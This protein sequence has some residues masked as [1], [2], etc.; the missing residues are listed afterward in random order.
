MSE[1]FDSDLTSV[2]SETVR[3]ASKKSRPLHIQGSGS[4]SFY[5]RRISG[6]ELD[7]SGHR[8]ILSYEPSELVLT[9]RGG[10]TLA[11]IES[12]LNA[13][14]QMLPFE[15]PRFG[16][17]ATIGGT[18]A[19]GF[20][21]PRRPFAGSARDFVLG[22]KMLDGA[23]KIASFGG[24]VMK[25][26]AGYDVSRLMTGALGTLGVILEVSL[27]V[28]PLPEVEQEYQRKMGASDALAEM[29]RLCSMPLPLS[30]ASHDG[31]TMRVRLSGTS[32][33]V[34]AASE[35]LKEGFEPSESAYFNRLREHDLNFFDE[36]ER[37]WRISLPADAPE[38]GVSG[39]WLADWA[40]ALRWGFSPLSV[41]EVRSEAVRLGGHASIFRSESRDDE[42]FTRLTP[43]IANLHARLKDKFDP[44]RILNPGILYAEL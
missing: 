22:V 4:K 40:G 30:A 5:G 12:I 7:V 17:D 29:Q 36:K 6:T 42:R 9:A 25:N 43:Q 18:V 41:D 2:L 38:L 33:G 1:K 20:S 16:P 23:G 21:G 31:E 32:S 8:G 15:P 13:S 44:Q 26:V 10:T 39:R 28:L 14:G 24:Q 34:E 11:E 3:E 27:K 19:C 35:Q 37:L